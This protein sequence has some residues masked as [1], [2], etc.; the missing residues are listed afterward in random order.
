MALRAVLRSR[1]ALR[2]PA[3]LVSAALTAVLLAPTFAVGAD[4]AVPDWTLDDVRGRPVNFH[5][6]LDRGPVLVSFW[7][8]WCGPCLKE[9]V[10]LA[11]L[12]TE[13]RGK[14]TVLAVNVDSPRSVHKVA[15]W[16]AAQNNDDVVVLLDTAGDVQRTMQ[17][18]GTMPMTMLFDAGGREVYRH[19]GYDAGDEVQ[20]REEVWR[21]LG[22]EVAAA[23]GTAALDAAAADSACCDV[24]A[25]GERAGAG[26]LQ[27]SNRLEYSYSTETEREI[28]ENWLDVAATRGRLT[29]GALLD[30]RQPAEEGD[31]GNELRHRYAQYRGEGVEVRAGHF[32]GMFG[33]G[34]LFA[35]QEDRTLRIDTAL[36]GLLVRLRGDRWRAATFTGAPRAL[37]LDVRGLDVEAD[38]LS[39]ATLGASALTWAG[40]ATPVRDGALL[41]DY[42]VSGRTALTRGGGSLYAEF[43]SQRTWGDDGAGDWKEFW[44]HGLYAGAAGATG[45]LSLSCEFM[46]YERF[47]ILDGADGRMALNNPPSL[48]REHLYNLLNRNPY[49]RDADDERGWQAEASW[50][51][52]GGWN[53]LV[54]A[55]RIESQAGVRHFREH[56]AQVQ[57]QD[58]GPIMV[59]AGLDLRDVYS[60][61]LLRDETYTTLVGEAIWYA[62]SRDSWSLKAEHQHVEDTGTASGGLGAFDRQFF[63]LEYARATRW[64][65][66]A[67]IEA[68]NKYVAQREFLEGAG[69]YPAVQAVRTLT[70][71]SLLSLWAGKRLGGYVCAG[72]VCKYEP[73]FEGVELFATFRLDP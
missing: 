40:P 18:G 62:T 15:P 16:A 49:L 21:L 48:T 65:L 72:G 30:A 28:V 17:V 73:A 36:D 14:L 23:A 70:D 2:L 32:Y 31:R 71:G 45:P 12:A 57:R 42:A 9:Q 64:T 51:G 56:Y 44:G 10:H 8:L 20:L 46:D 3:R 39:G 6:A 41:R 66:T 35:A 58:W 69:P 33:R 59:R 63:T 13:T 38:P 68:N 50:A 19:T 4:H 47:T 1:P 29:V 61:G 60:K 5:D 11:K 26:T 53:A 22:R 43:A 67:M 55:S 27:V 7:A 34:L 37:D 25:T 24:A 54:N 52:P